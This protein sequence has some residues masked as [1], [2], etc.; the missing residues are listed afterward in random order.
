MSYFDLSS[1]PSDIKIQGKFCCWKYER[2]DGRLTKVPYSP[3]TGKRVTNIHDY[4]S[5]DD[6]MEV[7]VYSQNVVKCTGDF[8]N[9]PFD[10]IGIGL[11]NGICGIDIDHCIEDDGCS[12]SETAKD[13]L[14]IMDCYAEYSPS[15]K[16][17][18]LL[19]TANYFDLD[20]VEFKHKYKINNRNIGVECYLDGVTYRYFTIT[21]NSINGNGLMERTNQLNTFLEKYMKRK[22]THGSESPSRVFNQ[23]SNSLS[24]SDS[25]LIDKAK[26]NYKTGDMF[27]RLWEGNWEGI[28][29]CPSHSEADY[30]LMKLLA[31]WTGKDI[32]RMDRLFRQSGLNRDKYTNRADYRNYL[33]E[34]SL[35]ATHNVYTPMSRDPSN[36]LDWDSW[37][38]D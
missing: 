10:G 3:I 26:R 14:D 12:L 17:L 28:P 21:G 36:N 34:H 18:H 20:P 8:E 35:N 1:I 37:I 5:F 24:L 4:S 9:G 33:I 6:A 29:S 16:G 31:F 13:I 38:N 25:E 22:V 7:L 32:S 23:P 11:V 30:E 15:G 27:T 2:R 19:F